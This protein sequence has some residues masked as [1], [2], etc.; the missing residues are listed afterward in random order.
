MAKPRFARTSDQSVTAL[1]FPGAAVAVGVLF[2]A[3]GT[4]ALGGVVAAVAVVPGVAVVPAV[5]ED[6][7][8]SSRNTI[9]GF[10]HQ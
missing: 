4:A 9:A 7:A 2:T 3:A 10:P 6:T 5:G 1:G 8:P